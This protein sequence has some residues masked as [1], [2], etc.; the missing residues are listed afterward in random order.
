M[1]KKLALSKKNSPKGFTLIELL[2]TIAIISILLSVSILSYLTL[3][4]KSKESVDKNTARKIERCIY[5]YISSTNDKD[6]SQ[7]SH[8]TSSELVSNLQK[9]IIIPQNTDNDRPGTYGPYLESDISITP[10]SSFTGWK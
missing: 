4:N 5:I 3:A 2:L 8:T 1:I 7:I 6:L 9:E 10:K